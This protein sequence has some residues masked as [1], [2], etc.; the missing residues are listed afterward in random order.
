MGISFRGSFYSFAPSNGLVLVILINNYFIC[1]DTQAEPLTFSTS[2][3]S[4]FKR[5]ILVTEC[6]FG[7]RSGWPLL[8]TKICRKLL[9]ISRLRNMGYL[10][11]L[12]AQL[13][14]LF[15]F[16]LTEVTKNLHLSL[17][18]HT[19]LQPFIRSHTWP[20]YLT[21][22]HTLLPDLCVCV[23]KEMFMFI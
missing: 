23:L 7:C 9:L 10:I 22:A 4:L 19:L 20:E 21:K 16:L 14:F 6:D 17:T 12:R 8:E 5:I 3:G 15:G 13:H 11:C 1:K 18:T 2:V